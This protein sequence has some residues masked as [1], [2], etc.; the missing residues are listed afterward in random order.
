MKS[1][2]IPM[3]IKNGRIVYLKRVNH[4]KK[5]D[6]DAEQVERS[7]AVLPRGEGSFIRRHIYEFRFGIEPE[8]EKK[9]L[10]RSD[11]YEN[12]EYWRKV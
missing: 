12:W 8:C 3:G 9:R 7:K 6:Y 5:F 11:I 2:T 1:Q 10:T 4:K